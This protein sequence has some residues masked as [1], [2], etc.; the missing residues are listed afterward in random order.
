MTSVG[1][2]ILAALG[3]LCL[4][5]CAV[6]PAYVRPEVATPVSFREFGDW[7]KAQPADAA[8]RGPW[9]EVFSDPVLSDLEGRVD[10]SNQSLK[11]AEAA[12]RQSNALLRGAQA[13]YWPALS[14]S[15]SASRSRRGAGSVQTTQN[16]AGTASW[17]L[18]V[19]GGVR[20]SVESA[21]ATANASAAQLAAVRLSLQAT[22]AT[23]YFELRVQDGIQSLLDATVIGYEQALKIA[24]NRYRAGVATRTAVVS[25]Q[26]QLLSVQAQQTNTGI[27]R[28][29]LEHA[30]AVLT[31]KA[32]ATFTLAAAPLP[33]AVPDVPVGLPSTL[34]QRR[35]DVAVAER[36]AA[37]ANAQIGVAIAAYFPTVTLSGSESYANS[38]VSSL[39]QIPNRVWSYGPSLAFSVFDG[40]ARRA[41]VTQARAAYDQSVA[42]YRET[43]LTAFQ[44]VED[45]LV[46][47]RIL[48]RQAGIEDDLVKSAREAESLTLN[49]YKAGTVPYSSVITS[50]TTRLSSEQS[51]L[52]VLRSRLVGSVSLVSALGGDWT[53]IPSTKTP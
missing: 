12:W 21:R 47:L 11:A 36:Q 31:G 18:D 50:Q 34:L 2:F 41:R 28:A 40:G 19:W 26:T 43:V 37:A 46:N 30:I 7:T 51:A 9:W 23:D 16:V 45:D 53:A 39:F 32:P 52:A 48:Q 13:S 8:P 22:L 20:R 25:A 24:D 35:P 3:S 17:E 27:L 33:A 49:Q 10:V 38:V 15:G 6:G 4:A 42:N 14:A 5:A 1:R 29:Q 44:Q